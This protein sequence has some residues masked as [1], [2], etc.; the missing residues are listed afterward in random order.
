MF[1]LFMRMGGWL[2]VLPLFVIVAAA[3]SSAGSTSSAARLQTEGVE[4]SATITG[5]FEERRWRP[6]VR[7]SAVEPDHVLRF[8]YSSGS[9]LRGDFH[10]GTGEARVSE[11]FYQNHEKGDVTP[12]RHLPDDDSVFELE[13]GSVS[14]EATNTM[15]VGGIVVVVCLPLF[16]LLWRNAARAAKIGERGLVAEGRVERIAPRGVVEVLEFSFNDSRGEL[17]RGRTFPRRRPHG[18]G[19]FQPGATLRI[20]YDAEQ[21]ALA[22][23][24]ED[25]GERATS[26]QE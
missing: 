7:S 18:F 23:W 10:V 19:E 12:L 25:L 16:I 8:S 3:I 11:A 2:A 24:A 26:R 5:K 15:L 13:P 9:I 14:G 1:R 20:L 21:P 6:G 4:A 17:R 22:Y